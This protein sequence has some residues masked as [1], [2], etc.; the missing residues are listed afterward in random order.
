MAFIDG[1]AI[2]LRSRQT[3]L[4]DKYGERLRR[5]KAERAAPGTR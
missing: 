2:E 5:I 4:R 3:E 1:A